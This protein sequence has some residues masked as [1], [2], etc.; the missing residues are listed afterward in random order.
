MITA[1]E[2]K[3]LT[4]PSKE[5]HLEFID[6]KIRTAIANNKEIKE[7]CIR[8]EPYAYWLYQESA[9]NTT[10]KAVIKELRDLGFK[11]KLYYYESQFVDIGLLI[12]WE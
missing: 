2:A 5:D 12:S 11:V 7:V 1:A 6:A 8:E 10:A 3:E 9:M 4:G